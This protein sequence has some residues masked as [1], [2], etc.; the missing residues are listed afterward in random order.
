MYNGRNNEKGIVQGG[1]KMPLTELQI[2]NAKPRGKPYVLSDGGGLQLEIRPSGNKLWIA[3]F[4]IEGKYT[5][6]SIGNYP[7]LG[8]RAAREKHLEVR[9]KAQKEPAPTDL[10]SAVAEEWYA[11]NIENV[12]APSYARTTLIRLQKH[13]IPSLGEVPVNQVTPAKVLKICR[14]F[15][16]V[17]KHETASRIKVIIGQVMR[18]AIITGR[19]E[20]DPTAPLKNALAP[21]RPKHFA[22]L[23]RKEDV[24]RLIRA[25]DAYQSPMVRL[26]LLFTVYTLGR[27]GEV[28]HAEWSEIDM[29]RKEWIIPSEKMKM[30][31]AHI[32]CLCA[33][34]LEVLRELRI[35]T[36]HQK[37]LF[38]SA[39]GDGRPMSENT[40]RVALRTMG[41]TNDEICPHGIRAM[42]STILNESGL[43]PGDVIERA[44]AHSEKDAIRAAYDRSLHLESRVKM[45][46]WWGDYIFSLAGK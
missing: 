13:I 7:D 32:V 29:E 23:T 16:D 38:P 21:R 9:A 33:P 27:P 45:M 44:L 2:R 42:G 8:I 24:Q 4:P 19:C 31:R 1:D 43:F 20:S 28:R 5:R 17:G 35:L 26:A 10:F 40:V 41:F 14:I 22:T 37:W 36:G 12:R 18:Y 46:E 34:C 25:I 15:E 39:R 3:R 11:R 30:G 6:R